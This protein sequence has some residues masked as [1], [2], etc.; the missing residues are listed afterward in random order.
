MMIDLTPLVQALAALALAALSAATPYLAPMLRRYLHVQLTATQAAT[1]QSAADAGAKQAY[2][3]LAANC[4]SY[5]DIPIRN[6]ALAKGV[7]HVLASAPEA[8]AALG[9]TPDHVKQMVDARFGGLLAS[10][11]NVSI[12]GPQSAPPTAG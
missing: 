4:A 3:Y 1:I 6:A 9:V 12:S 8:M 11:P 2:G 7:Q 5:L 10:D